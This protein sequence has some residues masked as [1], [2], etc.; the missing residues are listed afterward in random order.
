MIQ[1][2]QELLDAGFPSVTNKKY[3]LTWVDDKEPGEEQNIGFNEILWRQDIAK[4]V[5]ENIGSINYTG[6]RTNV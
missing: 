6:E 2:P 5:L 1:I 4:W 3:L